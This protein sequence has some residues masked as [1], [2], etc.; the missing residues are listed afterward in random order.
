MHCSGLA[1]TPP[2]FPPQSAHEPH[3][4]VSAEEAPYTLAARELST[5]PSDMRCGPVLG[6]P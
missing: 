3:S 1:P 6:P 5:S 4:Q 2:E